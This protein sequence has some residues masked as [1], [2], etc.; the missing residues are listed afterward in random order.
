MSKENKAIYVNAK[1]NDSFNKRLLNKLDYYTV[2]VVDDNKKSSKVK[3]R[4]FGITIPLRDSIILLEVDGGDENLHLIYKL[5]GK[6]P[7]EH[8]SKE[9]V[10]I[11]EFTINENLT[12]TNNSEVYKSRQR[13]G[14]K[15]NAKNDRHINNFSIIYDICNDISKSFICHVFYDID[16]SNDVDIKS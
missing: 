11:V 16:R 15:N 10:T 12:I 14:D 2:E 13:F 4:T 6:V 3:N 1:S 5:I 9:H 7:P 8:F